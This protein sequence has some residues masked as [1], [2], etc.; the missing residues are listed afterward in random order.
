M[1][2]IEDYTYG[3]LREL[4]NCSTVEDNFVESV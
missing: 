2:L 1:D 4:P 3:H